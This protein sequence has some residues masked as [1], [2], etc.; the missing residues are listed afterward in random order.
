LNRFS[1]ELGFL[2]LLWRNLA[3]NFNLMP[4]GSPLE[5]RFAGYNMV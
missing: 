1:S 4:V 2:R 3:L 5:K